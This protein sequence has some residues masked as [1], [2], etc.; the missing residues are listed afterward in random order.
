MKVVKLALL[1]GVLMS[2]F[3]FASAADKIGVVSMQ[4]VFQQTPQGQ[5]SLDKIK[6]SLTPQMNQLQKQQSQLSTAV[7]A[8][9]KN[10]PTMSDADRNAQEATLNQQQQ[11]FQQQVTAFQSNESQQQQA[12]AQKFQSALVNAVKAVAKNDGYTMI[13]T[14]QAIPYYNSS[15]DVSAEVVNLMKKMN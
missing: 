11:Q 1:A 15:Y 9:N 6:Q 8:F 5:A 2:V 12:A 3:S 13:M 10:G 4:T 7:A 14:D